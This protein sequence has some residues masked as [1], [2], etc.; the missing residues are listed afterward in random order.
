MALAA[1]GGGGR[2]FVGQ[3]ERPAP[4]SFDCVRAR[5]S[6]ITRAG[7]SSDIRPVLSVNL[8]GRSLV[9]VGP[10][11][12]DPT[13][14]LPLNHPPSVVLQGAVEMLTSPGEWAV[15]GG[16]LY[17]WPYLQPAANGS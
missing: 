6:V 11:S 13:T 8:T 17:Y 12:T 2:V 3:R 5:C 14:P 4:I 9:M 10:N 15:R 1:A 16:T 7:Y